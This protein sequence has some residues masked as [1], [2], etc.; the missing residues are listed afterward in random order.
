VNH[1][2]SAAVGRLALVRTYIELN[3][4]EAISLEDLARVAGI[5]RFHFARQFRACTGESPMGYLLRTRVER[6]KTLLRD[7]RA[8]VVDVSAELGFADQSHFTRTFRRLVGL[9]PSV[10]ARATASYGSR[11]VV[12][13][14]E[15]PGRAGSA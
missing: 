5:S 13:A 9:P 10:Y 1:E 6:A 12:V 11:G 7:S 8:R 3:L 4:G 14:P 15:R 2:H